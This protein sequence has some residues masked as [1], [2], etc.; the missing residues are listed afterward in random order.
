MDLNLLIALDALLEEESVLRAA[1][2]MH[3]SAPAMS[4]TL[5]RIREA[6][7]DPILVRAGR[8]L[9]PT[10]RAAALRPRVHSLVAEAQ[11]LLRKEGAHDLEKL[12]RSFVVRT[13]DAMVHMI[14][15][16]LI[17]ELRAAAPGVSLRF[18]PE[19]E[20]DVAALREGRVDLDIGVIGEMG[21]EIRLQTLF[22]DQFVGVVRRA[23]PL[24]SGKVTPRRFVEHPH[25]GISRMGK[26][27]GPI[28]EALEKKKLSR[29]VAVVVPGVYAAFALIARSDMVGA[30]PTCVAAR[31]VAELDLVSFPLPVATPSITIAQAWH[32]RFDADHAHRFLRERVRAVCK[33]A[34][35]TLS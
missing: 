23:H 24:A 5:S 14:G 8:G 30:V 26:V 28:D 3:L 13:S 18:V 2:R 25:I 11:G 22:V 15:V 27:R 21:P 20:E 12:H 34:S 29:T 10:P 32:P 31:A 4:R 1:K 17:G 33:E 7:G 9:V 6:L 16:E 19:G 35:R